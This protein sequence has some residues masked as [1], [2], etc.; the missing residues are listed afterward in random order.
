MP[1]S[2]KKRKEKVADFSKAKL[3]LGKG[4]AVANNAI[5]TSFKARSIVLPSQSIAIDKDVSEPITKRQLTFNDLL[6]HLKHYNA[7]QRKDAILGM[8]ELF[9]SNWELLGSY[10]TPLVTAIVR[11]IS[12]E[13]AGVRKQLLSFLSWLLPKIPSE[14]LIPHSP[15]LLLFTTSAQTHIFPEI[16]I[17]AIRFLDIL[18]DCIPDSVVAGWCEANEGHGS[19][20]LGGYLGI[21]NAGTKYG[22]LNGPLNATSTAS[23]VLTPASK[24]IVLRSLSNFLRIALFASN[25]TSKAIKEPITQFAGSVLDVVFMKNVFPSLESFD[26]FERLLEPVCQISKH[27]RILQI[28]QEEISHGEHCSDTFAQ[29]Y[30]LLGNKDEAWILQELG[31]VTDALGNAK[32]SDFTAN[33]EFLFHLANTL[34]STII[35]TYLD[36]APAVFSP[37]STPSETEVQLIVVIARI[38]QS[39]YRVVMQS[40]ENVDHSHIQRLEG[41]LGYMAPHFP[42]STRDSRLERSFDEF[43]LIFCELTSFAVNASGENASSRPKQKRSRA[44]TAVAQASYQTERVTQYITR[45]LR[46]GPAS[47]AQVGVPISPTAYSA[48]LP[49]IWSLIHNASS[50]RAA[51]A[52]EVLYAT[53]DHAIK[54]S[55]KSSCKRL[56]IEFVARLVLLTMEPNCH[57]GFSWSRDAAI[58][59]KFD[60]WVLHLPQVLWELGSSN[61]V[62]TEVILRFLLRALQR[63]PRAGE[64]ELPVFLNSRLV[65]YFYMEHPSRGALPGPYKKLPTVSASRLRFLVLDVVG[66]VLAESAGK[67]QVNLSKAVGMAVAGEEEQDYWLHILNSSFANKE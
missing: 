46:G 5:D 6:S 35:E 61:L 3:K 67:D 27:G 40:P 20:V 1:K 29:H 37:G 15:L 48:L 12:D 42:A 28:W 63:Q 18:L 64:S 22:E 4:K 38:A 16:R 51:E 21:L 56:T 36:S 60:A 13:D 62:G 9:D 49:T 55:S 7:S 45:R 31:S 25:A 54:V 8:R 17:D 59:A 44:A 10:I 32:E 41:I 26:S 33:I 53:L 52:E 19:R 58:K 39:L 14:N 50:T 57:G 30:P 43:N 11:V 23:V 34:H 65:P 47:S 2:A 24:L 66:T